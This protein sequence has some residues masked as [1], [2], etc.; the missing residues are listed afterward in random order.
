MWES[1]SKGARSCRPGDLRLALLG[2]VSVIAFGIILGPAPAAYAQQVISAS[3]ASTVNSDGTGILVNPDVD[4]TGSP[5]ISNNTITGTI[6]SQGTIESGSFGLENFSTIG[7]LTNTAGGTIAGPSNGIFNSAGSI[8]TLSNS[9]LL[10]GDGANAR[11][12]LRGDFLEGLQ[13]TGDGS[14]EADERSC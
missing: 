9:G 5:G 14:E 10:F 2:G 8:G 3:T 7:T 6:Y 1:D 11:G 12:L 13:D 4:L